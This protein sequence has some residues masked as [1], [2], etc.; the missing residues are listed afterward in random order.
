MGSDWKLRSVIIRWREQRWFT[1]VFFSV[2][3]P[4][5]PHLAWQ[6]VGH[7]PLI[8]TVLPRL[9]IGHLI[10]LCEYLMS[11]LGAVVLL[12]SHYVKRSSNRSFTIQWCQI[13]G[14]FHIDCV[15]EDLCRVFLITEFL[16]SFVRDWLLNE[17]IIFGSEPTGTVLSLI[18]NGQDIGYREAH[19]VLILWKEIVLIWNWLIIVVLSLIRLFACINRAVFRFT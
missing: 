1:Q 15:A 12:L 19:W 11:K 3:S 18:L 7:Q 9:I 8:S 13:I 5:V 16:E 2:F 14:L 6:I 4:F 10:T 17:R